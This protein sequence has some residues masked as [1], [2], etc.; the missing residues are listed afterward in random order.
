MIV[1]TARRNTSDEHGSSRRKPLP[2]KRESANSGLSLMAMASMIVIMMIAMIMMAMRMVKI[3]V[4]TKKLSYG[5]TR[6]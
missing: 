4:K 3:L 1:K 2:R 5:T 6:C